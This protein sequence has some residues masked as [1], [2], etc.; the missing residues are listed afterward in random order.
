MWFVGML[1]GALI[2]AAWGSHAVFAGAGLGLIAGVLYRRWPPS[3][4]STAD[5]SRLAIIEDAIRQLSVRVKALEARVQSLV[6]VPTNSAPDEAPQGPLPDA[7]V[8]QPAMA[9]GVVTNLAP[10][11]EAPAD[12]QTAGSAPPGAIADRQPAAEAHP[13]RPFSETPA[14][15]GPGWWDRLL[16]GN[17]VA[18]A[19][20]VILFLG[21]GF[22]LKYAYDNALLPVPLRLAGVALAGAALFI[23]G[24]R[25]LGS[26]RSY[27]LILQGAGIGL[28][29][30][31]VF[32]GLKV[33]ALIAP[34]VGFALFMLLG[35]LTTLL[36]VRQ[37]AAILAVLGLSGAFMAPV[38]AGSDSGSHVLLFSYYLLLNV[39][40]FAVSWFKSWRA[41]NLVGFG[42][43]FVVGLF[44]GWRNYRPELFT[45][46]EPFVIAFFL[47]YLAIP[48]LFAYRQPP[49]LR[50]LVDGTLV[51][52][53]PLTVAAMQA[54][55]VRGIEYGLAWSA[56]GAATLYATLVLLLWRREQMRVLA[57]A[58]AALAVVLGSLAVAFAFDAYPTFAFWTLEGAALVWIGL[59]QE[60]LAMRLFGL[61]LQGGGALLF[62]S[63]Y[64]Q[65]D[66]S[67]P[68][69]NDFVVGCALIALS[70]LLS[71]GLMHHKR[72][73][74]IRGGE[75]TALF[76][77]L[78]GLWWW[79]ATSFHVTGHALSPD[80]RP[81]ASLC[82]VMASVLLAEW[83]GSR[84]QWSALRRV[85]WLLPLAMTVVL[86]EAA[87]D[88][89]HPFAAYG[90]LVWPLAVLVLYATLKRQEQD[91]VI[92]VP[93][94]QHVAALWGVSVLLSWEAAWQLREAGLR[95]D[96][97]VAVW[98][99]LPALLLG[100]ISY[101]GV[102]SGWPWAS[103]PAAYRDIGLG[104]LALWCVLWSLFAMTHAARVAP[105]PYFPLLNVLDFAQLAVLLAT[106]LWFTIRA[107]D[108]GSLSRGVQTLLGVLA[109]LTLNAVVMRAVHHWGDVRYTL[110]AM[111]DSV[112]AQAALSLVWTTTA[113]LLMV[114]ARRAGLRAA[115]IGGAALL[116]V[117][118]GKLFLFDLA[119]A[120]TVER[121]VTFIG[122][123]IGLLAIGY[124]APVPPGSSE[125]G[126]VSPR[127]D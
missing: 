31:D 111:M 119:N 113:L 16:S 22:L 86:L 9:G 84:L 44:W 53:T 62:L 57:E 61:L 69:F 46:V 26:R 18:K 6:P 32:F 89:S 67:N 2:G 21:V 75:T 88:H 54:G 87:G 14:E 90:W 110:H 91:A 13:F 5:D 72:G 73:I 82:F 102:E 103:R 104:G 24:W 10:R 85:Q 42:F 74:L 83:A 115:W 126:E 27:A 93:A 98:G 51:F 55:L 45:S 35:I 117:V 59:R 29:Y 76:L 58:H 36:A 101:R 124:F 114:W 127:S 123:G 70:S 94:M 49:R 8:M 78:W 97:P 65:Y 64:R 1:A 112:L 38:L 125:T 33:Y 12:V 100:G 25:L 68:W 66:L 63:H 30:L 116:A 41:L 96:W 118:V 11:P 7:S 28:L 105:L 19:G 34:P 43:T 20:V 77:L 92:P 108:S 3:S 48:V 37:D 47:I 60:R 40:I 80:L 121:I 107:V 4:P 39:F 52:G 122:V 71:S 109:F 106:G 56:T 120:G 23:T 99:L 81:H 95:G 79:F 17:L 50:G 15:T